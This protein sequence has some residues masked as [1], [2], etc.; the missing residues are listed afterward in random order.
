MNREETNLFEALIT[1]RKGPVFSMEGRLWTDRE[2]ESRRKF[3][4]NKKRK[5][6][7]GATARTRLG[8]K[9]KKFRRQGE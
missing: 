3:H 4:F 2:D 9:G 7:G 6:Q 1:A 5:G 8:G